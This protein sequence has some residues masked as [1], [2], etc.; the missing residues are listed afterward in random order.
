VKP[1]F[2]ASPAA[3]RAWLAEHGAT[4]TELWVGFHKKA[5]GKPSITWRE[6]VDEA[7]CFGWID[8]VRRS[9]DADRY[10]QRFTPRT[11]R[12]TW[13]AVNLARAKE[14]IRLR[15]M[16][17]AGRRAYERRDD[18]R[19]GY[20]YE[21]LSKAARLD[22][23]AERAFRAD[24]TAWAYFEAQIPSY[25]RAAIAW[26]TNAVKE[27]TRRRRLTTLIEDS[28]EARPIKPLR[29]P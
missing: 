1:R 29:R 28:H 10:M 3:F 9:V 19:S 6:A 8:G 7:L 23:A 4:S 17:A 18:K 27:E 21:Q 14:L 11:A 16:R 22:E 24:A 5:S 20:S 25:R 2:F 26:V 15:R 12:S 13:S